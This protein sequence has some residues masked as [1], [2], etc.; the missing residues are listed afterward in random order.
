VWEGVGCGALVWAP[1]LFWALLV[2]TPFL[3]WVAGRG[4][5]PA[6]F[7]PHAIWYKILRLESIRNCQLD[8]QHDILYHGTFLES[9]AGQNRIKSSK[10]CQLARTI[11]QTVMV[12]HVN[13]T[14][15][16]RQAPPHPQTRKWQPH[17][18]VAS[19]NTTNSVNATMIVLCQPQR[20]AAPTTWRS[21]IPRAQ[22]RSAPHEESQDNS[23]ATRTSHVLESD[24]ICPEEATDLC[25]EDTTSDSD[26]SE[27]SYECWSEDDD[28]DE[29]TTR[30]LPWESPY[31]APYSFTPTY[32]DNNLKY[33]TVTRTSTRNTEW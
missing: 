19:I 29:Y 18:P 6:E 21:D 33:A 30:S 14:Y 22:T 3:S 27:N 31:D 16:C 25:S 4:C 7:G 20:Q 23:T 5:L 28:H 15:L 12:Q 1:S 32:R 9:A 10:R 24:A 2:W 8:Q 11:V 17:Y 13:I 26:S